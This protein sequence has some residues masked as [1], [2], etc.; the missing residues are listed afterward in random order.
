MKILSISLS[1][2]LFVGAAVLGGDALAATVVKAKKADTKEKDE[3]APSDTPVDRSEVKPVAKVEK[4]KP[5]AKKEPEKIGP[6][7]L[8]VYASSEDV[9]RDA[10]ADARRDEAISELSKIIPTFEEGPQKADLLYRLAEL[11]WEKAKFTYFQEFRG[12]DDQVQKWAD[13]GSKKDNEPKLN[14]SKSEGLKK[15]AI[16]IYDQ[17]LKRYPDY[18]RTDEV[19][20]NKA[21]STYEAGDKKSAIELYFQLAKRFPDS[22]FVPDT[23]L[24]LG[25]HYFNNNE[26]QKA[27][28]AYQKA[29]QTNKPKIYAFAL[30][31]LAWCDY[32]A[33]DYS[34]ALQK[35]K[36]VVD[37]SEKQATKKKKKDR[38]Q[39]RQEALKDML[40]AFAQMDAIDEAKEYYT[41]KLEREELAVYLGKLGGLYEDQGKYDLAVKTYKMV[42][43]EW[44]DSPKA[45]QYQ[46]SII[47]AYAQM[48]KRDKVREE[49]KRLISLYK[50][51][52]TWA[53]ANKANKSA[54]E[55]AY[56]LTE[57]SLR[58]LTTEFHAEAQKVAKEGDRTTAEKSYSLARDLYKEYLDAFGDSENAYKMRFNY[59]EILYREKSY[60]KAAE[61]FDLIAAADPKGKYLKDAAFS[62]VQ[63]W[64]LIVEGETAGH[65]K[66]SKDAKGKLK[67]LGKMSRLEKGKEYPELA[68]PENYKKL[69][70]ACERFV[71]VLPNDPDVVKVKF[72]EARIYFIH[73]HFE[74]AGKAFGEII[75]RWPN[76]KL[77]RLAATFVLEGFNI[78]ERWDELNKYSREI[79]KHKDLMKDEG[80]A[81][82]VQD[83]IEGSS[84]KIV[85]GLE[86]K[87]ELADAGK[88]YRAFVDEFPKSKFS[89][90]S[91][92]N[93]MV[94]SDKAGQL[95]VALE[96]AEKLL[97]EYPDAKTKET[98]TFLVASFYERVGEFE[99]ALKGYQAYIKAFPKGEKIQDAEFNTALFLDALALNKEAVAAFSAF[100]DKYPKAKDQLAV[101]QRIGAIY[102]RMGDQKKVIEHAEALER[103]FKDA[104]V[105]TIFEGLHKVAKIYKTQKGG[106]KLALAQWKIIWDRFSKLKGEDKTDSK[107][108]FAAAQSRFELYEEKFAEYSAIKLKGTDKQVGE[109]LVK[110]MKVLTD[111]E[112]EYTEILALGNGDYGIAALFRIGAAY[113][114]LSKTIFDAPVP[115]SLNEEQRE[116]YSSELQNKAFPL[117]EKAIEA[118]EKALA[119]SNELHIYNEWSLKAQDRM[120]QFK[121]G[122][123][124]EVRKFPVATQDRFTAPTIVG[125][126]K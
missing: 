30:Y 6:A 12:Y 120:A 5:K 113:Q 53:V 91:L 126:E 49:V 38:V 98:T 75:E 28:T 86:A 84:F 105:G 51:S 29:V 14:N 2:A 69:A 125:V 88:Q 114:D 16:A 9:E 26:L 25:E 42:N 77:G 118:Y 81:K 95:D 115:K 100:L 94:I 59:A 119:K 85:Q 56:E 96:S 124:P 21:N 45:P 19:L 50:P 87:G 108:L 67:E 60:E 72:K 57:R 33:Q 121:P 31:K 18:A 83:F 71:K 22:P 48:G 61:Q 34:G 63:A 43:L 70:L 90:T 40:L 117:E 112:K 64:E 103:R 47:A 54:L 99:K 109:N 92:Y 80:F 35:F 39:L 7:K 68:I 106:D 111:V 3:A 46:S 65:D 107:V 93:A 66:E 104:P 58:E 20:F 11:Y 41:A 110:K 37:Y 44:P 89:D 73:N 123:F 82:E 17:I 1:G 122:E 76:D 4:P 15:Q 74:E 10:A 52:G 102:E 36:T 24:A 27:I 13:A 101:Y 97:K 62:S 78:R 55:E 23:Y 32:N 79:K 116:I 8:G